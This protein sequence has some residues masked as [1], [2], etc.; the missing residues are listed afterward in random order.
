[1]FI[2]SDFTVHKYQLKE[3]DRLV[4]YSDGVP[5]CE[6]KD[7]AEYGLD[8]LK[9]DVSESSSLSVI[10]ATNYIEGQL[11]EWQDSPVFRD[12]VSLLV[13]DYKGELEKGTP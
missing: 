13:I 6:A 11:L 10:E 3:N 9:V 2:D 5:D 1:M 12:D 8:R 4:I 7:G